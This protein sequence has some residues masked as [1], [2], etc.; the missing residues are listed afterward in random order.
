MDNSDEV[1]M[2]HIALEPSGRL[3]PIVAAFIPPDPEVLKVLLQ[4]DRPNAK[5]VDLDEDHHYLFAFDNNL[6]RPYP[7]VMIFRYEVTEEANI[8][9]DMR[10]ED[11]RA[12]PYAVEHFLGAIS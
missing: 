3:Q 7:S 11:L 12:V 4:T 10:E 5:S 9:R 8:L 1:L 2:W 6:T